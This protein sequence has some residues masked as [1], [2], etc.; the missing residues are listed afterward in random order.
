M[1]APPAPQPQPN[2]PGLPRLD[3]SLY[4]PPTFTL[5]DDRTTLTS[6]SPPL[7]TYPATLLQTIQS[8]CTIPPKPTIRITGRPQGTAELDFD[9][10]VNIM[11]LIVPDAGAGKGG[12]GRMNYVKLI[13]PGETGY[14]GDFKKSSF[15][16][17]GSLEEWCR[18][19][20]EHSA[21]VKQ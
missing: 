3:Y 17:K 16:E 2:F 9:V 6:Y 13:G 14:R 20:C 12:R 10:K 19:Y 21:S 18:C 11:N 8:L 4:S 7:S 1:T 15:P 5:S